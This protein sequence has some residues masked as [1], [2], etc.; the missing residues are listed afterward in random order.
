MPSEPCR[1][2][3]WLPTSCSGAEQPSLVLSPT[4]QCV[5]QSFF[6][7]IGTQ[8]SR[9]HLRI[10]LPSRWT[11]TCRGLGR[12]SRLERRGCLDGSYPT[13]LSV[14]TDGN[15]CKGPLRVGAKRRP[16]LSSANVSAMPK[17]AELRADLDAAG[18]RPH[19][20]TAVLATLGAKMLAS[21]YL[22]RVGLR[23]PCAQ[24]PLFG[25]VRSFRYSEGE[26]RPL[27]H[28]DV[29]RDAIRS[30]HRGRSRHTSRIR[31]Q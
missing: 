27:P 14:T 2:V 5:E 3:R 4:R 6:G 23:D 15:K 7:I 24:R 28:T 19:L 25:G 21:R 18:P 16:P 8:S 12:R 22:A 1:T 31:W 9:F 29:D 13:A 20:I 11:C 10:N 17:S 26:R 30:A